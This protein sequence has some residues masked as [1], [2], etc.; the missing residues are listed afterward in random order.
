MISP[1]RNAQLITGVV[2]VLLGILA[3][4]VILDGERESLIVFA[5]AGVGI[6]GVLKTLVDWKNGLYLFITWMLF[7]DLVRKYM[8]NNMLIYFAKDF[9]IFIV[10]LS[11]LYALRRKAVQSFKPRF[12]LP[13]SLFFW[14]ALLQTFNPNSP[15]FFLGILGMKLYFYYIPLVFLG[16]GL[17]ESE[18][19][20]HR[21]FRLTLV[22]ACVIAGLGIAQAILGHTFLNPDVPAKDIKELSTLYRYAPISGQQLY[23]PTSVFVSDGRFASYMFLVWLVGLGFGAFL[24][25][26][27]AKQ[28]KS[29]TYFTL[30]MVIVAIVLSGSRGALMWS[31]GAAAICIPAFLWGAPR[32]QGKASRIVRAIQRVTA[33]GGLSV[34]LLSITYPKALDSRVA[35]YAETLG[36]NSPKSELRDRTIDYPLKN[37]LAAFDDRHWV[38]GNG[39]G[40][41]SLGLQYV[42]RIL[43][44]HM[45]IIGVENGY[46]SL[47]IEL[48]IAGLILWIVWTYSVVWTCWGMAR[49]LKGTQWFPLGFTIFLYV[50]LL[51]IPMSYMSSVAIQN[52]VMSC[53]AWL[54]VG[55]LF[56][57]PEIAAKSQS[58]DPTNTRTQTR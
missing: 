22:I 5:L 53:Y 13:L 35:F 20:V 57:L 56:R 41:A 21:F 14:F 23:R 58:F 48:G 51:L 9:L 45:R 46:G 12:L 8:G 50:T 37:F 7:E 29:L 36:I 47:V 43:H 16:Y 11:F 38:E 6:F 44:V 15:S 26:R 17:V 49:R 32:R 33:L 34:L 24:V 27:G 30:S 10:Y 39:T 18:R 55:V 2:S 52:Y 31:G 19:G 40:T 3:V 28:G 42:Q 54:L 25:L 1:R 4:M